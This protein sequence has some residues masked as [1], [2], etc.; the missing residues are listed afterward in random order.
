VENINGLI[1]QYIPKGSNIS[2]YS[3]GDIWKIEDKLNNRPRKGLSFK[4]PLEVMS[5]NNQF[6]SLDNFG[7][8]RLNKKSPSVAIEG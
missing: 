2:Q 8:I 7:I 5:E 4:T 1:R 6:K 3:D